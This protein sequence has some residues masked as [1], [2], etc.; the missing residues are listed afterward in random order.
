M[1]FAFVMPALSPQQE[2]RDAFFESLKQPENRRPERW[3]LD[4][5][6]YLHHP[7]RAKSSEKYWLPSREVLEEIQLTGD[8]FFPKRWL[9]ATFS[10][11]RSPEAAA[12]V[13][14]FL[15]ERPDYPYRLRN[16]ILQAADLLLKVGLIKMLAAVIRFGL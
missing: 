8:I 16:K 5:L 12:V 15:E 3:T 13:K 6:D 1:P 9:V 14:R 11:H 10:G 2:V 7:L 4:G